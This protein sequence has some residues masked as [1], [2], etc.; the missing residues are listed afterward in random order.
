MCIIFFK[1]DPRPISA[2]RLVLASNRDEIY[3]RPSKP[4]DFWA[5]NSDILSG[6][7][8]EEGKEGGT[9]LGISRKGKFA[10]LTNYLQ[11]IMNPNAHGRGS[12]VSNF[13]TGNQ[14]SLSYL[15]RISTEGHLYNGFN[16]LAADFSNTKED[17]MCYYG[18]QSGKEPQLLQPGIYG[19]S[20][21]LLDTP[22]NK[23]LHGKKLF[24]EITTKINEL[25]AEELANE[26]IHLMNDEEPHFPDPGIEQQISDSMRPMLSKYSSV[27]VR[28]TGYGTRTN[29]VILIDT[30]GRVTFTERTMLNSDIHQWK[31]SSYHFELLP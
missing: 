29:T 18:N 26:L 30:K 12:L 16:L 22:W 15:K 17:V 31:V 19:L 9:W 14:D 20:N 28:L 10:T 21:S 13:L 7:D 1:F 24:T 27:C 6:L 23:V 11:P 3:S 8:M 5:S 2:Y 25:S 4:A